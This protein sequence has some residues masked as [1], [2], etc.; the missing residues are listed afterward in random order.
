MS[1]KLVGQLCNHGH[2][3][4]LYIKEDYRFWTITPNLL[5]KDFVG[6]YIDLAS[7]RCRMQ[8]DYVKW[9]EFVDC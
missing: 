3:S 7:A 2:D 5:C 8:M 4:I 1:N 6:S 9:D